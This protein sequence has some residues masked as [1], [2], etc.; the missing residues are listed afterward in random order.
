MAEYVTLFSKSMKAYLQEVPTL[1]KMLQ[2][3]RFYFT[4]FDVF[5]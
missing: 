4:I 1:L 2:S 3:V 5:T